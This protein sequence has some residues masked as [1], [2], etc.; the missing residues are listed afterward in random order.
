MILF[1]S[2]SSSISIKIFC[3]V[4]SSAVRGLALEGAAQRSHLGRS[5][6]L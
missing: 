6:R 5:V 2:I 4:T 1:S 3:D